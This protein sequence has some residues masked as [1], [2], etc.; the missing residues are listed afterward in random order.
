MFTEATN[1]AA[2]VVVTDSWP[3]GLEGAGWALTEA[4]LAEMGHPKLLPTPPFSM[5]RELS[6]DPTSY[7]GFAG[8]D[9]K[10]WLLPVQKAILCY[11]AEG[12]P[13]HRYL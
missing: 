12:T 10:R 2:D 9:Q 7:S 8:Y 13:H 3:S 11:A 5:D 1:I 4:H 6:F